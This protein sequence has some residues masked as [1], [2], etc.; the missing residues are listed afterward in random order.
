[1]NKESTVRLA[2]GS[3][4][5]CDQM[6][7]KLSNANHVSPRAQTRDCKNGQGPGQVPGEPRVQSSSSEAPRSQRQRW[8]AEFY[9]CGTSAIITVRKNKKEPQPPQRSVSLLQPK[10]ASHPSSK[11]YS[12]P[13]IGICSS[14]SNQC[15]SSSSSSTSSCSSPPP[16]QTSAITGPDPRGWKLRPKSSSSSHLTNRLSLPVIFPDPKASPVPNSQLVALKQDPFPKTKPPRRPKPQHR[17]SDSSIFLRYLATPLPV[18]TLHELRALHLQ[19]VVV[20]DESGDVF[21]GDVEAKTIL[22][23]TQNATT[24]SREDSHG[25]T[26]STTDCSF[27][28]KL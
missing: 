6:S 26:K 21:S 11:R 12:C 8:S 25:T 7:K 28:P 1:M 19:R 2:S 17:H 3:Y 9:R 10:I 15:S 20:S 18:V 22:S 27:P 5:Q 4:A 23:A 16:V 14:P 13:P 24:C